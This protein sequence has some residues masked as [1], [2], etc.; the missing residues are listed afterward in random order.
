MKARLGIRIN[1][2][3]KATLDEVC[4]GLN[5]NQSSL[6]ERLIKNYRQ[7]S[8]ERDRKNYR[9]RLTRALESVKE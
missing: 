3:T 1:A 9:L 2:E 8:Y 4:K 6:I 5:T 7:R